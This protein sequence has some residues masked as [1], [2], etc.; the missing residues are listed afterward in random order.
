MLRPL[1][2]IVAWLVYWMTE[3]EARFLLVTF[4]PPVAFGF[5]SGVSSLC[6]WA[7]LAS[8]TAP[9]VMLWVLAIG[10]AVLVVQP[11]HPRRAACP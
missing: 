1:S 7:T 2:A 4:V 5:T 11:T 10:W 9:M 6:G 8:L 3:R